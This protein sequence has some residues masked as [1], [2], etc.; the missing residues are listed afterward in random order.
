MPSPASCFP[1]V[2]TARKGVSGA[3]LQCVVENKYN[4]FNSLAKS[5]AVYTTGLPGE[6]EWSPSPSHGPSP[7]PAASHIGETRKAAANAE[8][9]AM[10]GSARSHSHNRMSASLTPARAASTAIEAP[11]SSCARD[12]R[13]PTVSP[14]SEDWESRQKSR[15]GKLQPFLRQPQSMARTHRQNRAIFTAHH[16]CSAKNSTF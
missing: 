7:I 5:G 8:S 6:A 14:V 12:S 13:P 1:G 11:D 4:K 9:W 15:L 10:A 2:I 3:D 16:P